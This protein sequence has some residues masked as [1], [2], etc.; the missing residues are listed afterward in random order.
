MYK[1]FFATLVRVK[2]L[3]VI[4]NIGDWEHYFA[5]IFKTNIYPLKT[6]F[7]TSAVVWSAMEY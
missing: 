5:L 3:N 4:F 1:D 7:Q 2:N 6:Q